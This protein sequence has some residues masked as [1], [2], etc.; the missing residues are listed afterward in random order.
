MKAFGLNLVLALIWFF[1]GAEPDGARLFVGFV[2]GFG[3]VRLFRGVL[4]GE[5]YTRRAIALAVFLAVFAREL[6]VSNLQLARV[7]LFRPNAALEPAV[8]LYPVAGLTKLEILLISHCLTLTPGS[9]TIDIEAG[10]TQLRLHALDGAD[11]AAVR[12]GIKRNLEARILAFT[13]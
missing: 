1:L 8:F 12:A 13:R 7:V 2:L 9:S 11:V 5:S 6:L 10:F 3:L 4:G